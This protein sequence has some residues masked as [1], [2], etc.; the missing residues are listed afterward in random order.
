MGRVTMIPITNET[1]KVK[2]RGANHK[3]VVR[4]STQG[5]ETTFL[6]HYLRRFAQQKGLA[7]CSIKGEKNAKKDSEDMSAL[8]HL[9][10]K[11]SGNGFASSN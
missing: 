1:H 8:L 4:M 7:K 6:G 11:L 2:K 9:L 10:P 3:E 5:H